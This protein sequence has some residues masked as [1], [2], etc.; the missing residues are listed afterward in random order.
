MKYID[1]FRNLYGIE[2]LFFV[3]PLN[4]II[5]KKDIEIELLAYDEH[6]NALLYDIFNKNDEA[7]LREKIATVAVDKLYNNQFDVCYSFSYTS[8]SCI[9][10]GIIG[11]HER[12]GYR[13]MFIELSK[14]SV[15]LNHLY[16]NVG[17]VIDI[18]D[19]YDYIDFSNL[20]N[21]GFT[22]KYHDEITEIFHSYKTD[23][24]SIDQVMSLIRTMYISYSVEKND[25]HSKK[26]LSYVLK[27]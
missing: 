2:K 15:R 14:P 16:K 21:L 26:Y 4:D 7:S 22:S 17:I 1:G 11:S 6:K 10:N 9:E 24:L 12:Y 25:E 20:V 27:K 13:D 23:S 5:G 3:G 19:E 18:D 8:K